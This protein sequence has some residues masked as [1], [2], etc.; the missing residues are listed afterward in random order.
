MFLGVF[1][2]WK[3]EKRVEK[4]QVES[5]TQKNVVFLGLRGA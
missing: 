2:V 1:C 4:Y 5:K 3:T